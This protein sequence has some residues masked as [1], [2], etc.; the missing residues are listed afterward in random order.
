LKKEQEKIP[1]NAEQKEPGEVSRR[2]FL[3]GAGTVVVGGAIGAGLL[4]GCGETVTTT[5]KETSTKTV[6]TTVTAPGTTETKTVAGPAGEVITVTETKTVYEGGG[7]AVEPAFEPETT[8]FKCYGCNVGGEPAAID[9]KNGRIVRIRPI[10][11]KGLIPEDEMNA[12]VWSITSTNK[13]SGITKTFTSATRSAPGY[14]TW[15]YKKRIYAADRVKYPLQRVDWEPGGDVTKTN[16]QNRGKSKYKRIT[17][18]QASSIIAS[19]I[20]RVQSKY[21]K[22]GVCVVGENG[23]HEW[24]GVHDAGGQHVALMNDAGGYTREIRN[25]D[26]WEGWYWGTAH[27]WGTQSRGKAASPKMWDIAENTEMLVG[28]TDAQATTQSGCQGTFQGRQ[29]QWYKD[30]GIKHIH[31]S[32]DYNYTAAVWTDKW[33][34]VI[35]GT[36]AAWLLGIVYL[37]I[38]EDLYD[39]DYIATHTVGFDEFKEYVLGNAEDGIPKTPEWASTICG[40]PEWTIKALARAWGTKTTMWTGGANFMRGPYGTEA[41]RMVAVC[42]AMQGMGKLGVGIG[43]GSIPDFPKTPTNNGCKR[44]QN[45]KAVPQQIPRTQTHHAILDGHCESWGSTAIAADVTDQFIKYSY[46]IDASEGGTECHMYWSEKPTNT[47]NWNNGFRFIDAIRDPKVEFYLVNHQWLEYDAQFADIILPITSKVEEY[48][49]NSQISIG[50]ERYALILEKQAIEPIG[51]SRSDYQAAVAIAEKMEQYP[52]YE[53]IVQKRTQGRTIEEWVKYGYDN[54]RIQD[55]VSW[56][57]FNERQIY[58]APFNPDYREVKDVMQL[59][60]LD[61]EA[62]PLQTPSGLLEIT[63][64]R[65]RE[66]FPDDEERYP[67]PRYTPG[68]PASEGW[69]HD[70]SLFGEKCKQYPILLECNHPR[71]R[72]HSQLENI[73]WLREI[74]TMKIKGYDGYLY[75]PAWIHPTLAAAKGIEDGDIIKIW[76]DRGTVL[77]AAY[78]TE[79]IQP[80]TVLQDHAAAV[81][82]IT[83]NLD[84]GG[85]NNLISPAGPHSKNCWG[86]ATTAFLVDIAKVTGDEMDGWRKAYPE[87]FAK[88]YDPACG[89]VVEAFM[90]GG[91]D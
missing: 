17:W 88:N 8:V 77:G 39:K 45:G 25:A 15:P 62:N 55:I 71:W 85:S 52:E 22:Y 24:K 10:E 21:G 36:D 43:A 41:S 29:M 51:E 11:F 70:E 23:H 82:L 64:E 37:W 58:M 5:V 90:E 75:E 81:D 14:Q 87:A 19:E 35:A 56:E 28:C 26:S 67:H 6:P 9:V 66:H 33:I 50:A 4:S 89:L 49:L 72:Q 7:G 2:D 86:M 74:R 16:P 44:S 63:S 34:P 3:V 12:A 73:T 65:L 20:Q 31:I 76:N 40:A 48:D 1:V 59:F 54:S 79:R 60:Y 78:V 42:L 80:N 27:M 91:N 61:P 46:P 32:P 83:D 53:G 30:L 38:Q 68:G 13:G 18:D 57:D 69:T 47:S 84:R